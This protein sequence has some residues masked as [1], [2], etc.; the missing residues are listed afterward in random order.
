MSSVNAAKWWPIQRAGAAG[1][2]PHRSAAPRTFAAACDSAPTAALGCQNHHAVAQ[3]ARP[4]RRASGADEQQLRFAATDRESGEPVGELLADRDR[5][6]AVPGLRAG[7]LTID[8][9]AAH[10]NP[11]L[12]DSKSASMRPSAI[13]SEIRKPVEANKS[14]N[15]HQPSGISAKAALVARVS[16]SVARQTR[17]R[18]RAAVAARGSP[19]AN[20]PRA[21]RPGQR[22]AGRT[23]VAAQ[24]CA[25]SDRRADARPRCSADTTNP[26]TPGRDAR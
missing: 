6:S 24:R 2:R 13:A 23:A 22:G 1:S 4:Q 15:G 16:E 7:E 19:V 20:Y 9:R 3:I 14:N 8:D 11:R 17:K 25:P 26:R 21:G 18:G 12:L 10:V 5:A